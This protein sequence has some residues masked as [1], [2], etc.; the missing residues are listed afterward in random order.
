MTTDLLRVFKRSRLRVEGTR[1]AVVDI[2]SNS[3]RLVVY[4]VRGACQIPHYN[5]KVMAGLGRG[6][7]KT[8]ALNSEGVEMAVSALRRFRAITQ[9]LGNVPV[10]AFATAA[11]R[12]ATNGAAFVARVKAETGID[13]R[14][15]SGQ[16]EAV[17]SAS[18]VL[19]GLRDVDG[20]IGDLGGSSLELIKVNG[21]LGAGETHLVGPLA[22][23]AGEGAFD[24]T[25]VREQVARE[26]ARSKVLK[27]K[28]GTFYAVGGSWRAFASVHMAMTEYPLRLLQGYVM[29][30]RDVKRLAKRLM[31]PADPVQDIARSVSD[32]RQPLLPYAATVLDEVFRIGDF[33][34]LVVSANGLREGVLL[35]GGRIAR[36]HGAQVLLDGLETVGRLSEAQLDFCEALAAFVRPVTDALEPVWGSPQNDQLLV[37]AACRTADIGASLHPDDRAELAYQIVLRGPYSGASHSER[38]FIALATGTRYVRGMKPRQSEVDLITP[39]QEARARQIGALMRVGGIYSGRTADVLRPAR[40][41]LSGGHLALIPGPGQGDMV[42]DVVARR[43]QQAASSLGVQSL[44]G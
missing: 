31:D 38:V 9:G 40:L 15:L 41:M 32:K 14:V 16:E 33:D 22:L 6:L 23:G 13:V 35:H 1:R 34:R 25:A 10:E 26:L 8:G 37:E 21:G 30:G 2:G 18:G 43:L 24:A 12:T 7:S 19:A 11:V 5:E 29:P 28:T 3:V 42:S 36:G 17:G 4:H 39:A 20:V 27:S 44:V